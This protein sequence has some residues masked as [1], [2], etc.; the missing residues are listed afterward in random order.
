M[1]KIIR[2]MPIMMRLRFQ[3]LAIFP[4]II[5]KKLVSPSLIWTN[6]IPNSLKLSEQVA[7]WENPCRKL[8]QREVMLPVVFGSTYLWIVHNLLK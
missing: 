3:K 6:I 5:L 2:I 8:R 1:K 4:V 7:G